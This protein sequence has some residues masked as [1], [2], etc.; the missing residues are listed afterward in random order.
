[1]FV[2]FVV[3]SQTQAYKNS[4]Y[5][6]K[7][8]IFVVV[9]P[10]LFFT[11]L[12]FLACFFNEYESLRCFRFCII[13]LQKSSTQTGQSM[14][15]QI[16]LIAAIF[17]C[18]IPVINNGIYTRQLSFFLLAFLFCVCFLCVVLLLLCTHKK[19]SCACFQSLVQSFFSFTK[20]S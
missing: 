11:L 15:R 16:F 18:W 4:K 7:A 3:F 1:M 14:W 10:D 5:R 19:I 13:V 9:L 8:I 12:F 6:Q 17:Y 20:Y 2:V